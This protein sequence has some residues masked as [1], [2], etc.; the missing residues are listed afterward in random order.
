MSSPAILRAA[1][2]RPTLVPGSLSRREQRGLNLWLR[3][4]GES[5]W[6]RGD[7]TEHAWLECLLTAS[8]VD[9]VLRESAA[10][11][12]FVNAADRVTAWVNVFGRGEWIG[13]H[14]DAD[15]DVQLVVPIIVPTQGPGGALWIDSED[16]IIPMGTGDLVAFNA[17]RHLH[18]TTPPM[19]AMD[20][21][22]TLNVRL[23][24][25]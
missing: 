16:C 1:Q 15:G 21:R 24:F 17:A 14:R 7:D 20:S 8:D 5:R 6:V 25:T 23:W 13:A 10:V 3:S 9:S 19:H 12:Q 18:G 22:A 11:A 2:Y 4:I